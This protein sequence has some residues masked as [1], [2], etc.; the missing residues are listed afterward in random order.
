M[1]VLV[2]GF[3]RAAGLAVVLPLL[4]GGCLARVLPEPSPP[5][6]TYDFGPL[7]DEQPATLGLPFRLENVDAPSWLRTQNIYYRRLVEQQAA[8][9]P[10]TRNQWIAST[11]ELFAER[12]EDRLARAAPESSI[13][14]LPLR[15]EIVTFE[16]VY[17]AH[18]G[19]YV[20]AR[21]RAAYDDFDGRTRRRQFEQRREAAAS[22]E[23][24]TTELPV[25]AD[26]LLD[27]V[28]DWL[29]GETLDLER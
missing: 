22:V 13:E 27:G 16:H 29:R 4:L 6:V 21:A 8:L 1:R 2:P 19:S 28:L 3:V 24:A 23:G 25:V 14:G 7:P 5:P 12:L 26:N 15:L 20:I 10:Y 18:G 9:R 17:T 11:P